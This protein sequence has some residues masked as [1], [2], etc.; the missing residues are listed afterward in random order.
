[1]IYTIIA[2]NGQSYDLPTKNI[3]VMESLSNVLK[4]DQQTELSM[5]QK[6][7]KILDFAVNLLGADN[8][9]EILGSDKVND[10][11]VGELELLILKVKA[12]YDKPLEEYK[13]EQLENSLDG[14][15]TEKLVALT[16][17][18]NTISNANNVM[19]LKK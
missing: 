7:Q 19:A 18:V 17:A 4:I 3:G 5:K 15:P 16:K 9:K 11:D 8:V 2:T 1:M 14:I 12:A 6:Y 13:T 10:I